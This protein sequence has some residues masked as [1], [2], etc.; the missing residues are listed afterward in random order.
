MIRILVAD[1]HPLFRAGVAAVI[2]CQADMVVVGEATT[3]T[4]AVAMARSE[5][6]D[7]VL[8]DLQMPDMD[9]LTALDAIRREFPAIRI[10]VVTTYGGDVQKARALRLGACGYLLKETLHADLVD[11]IRAVML[12]ATADAGN[13][14][15]GI[16][17]A[18][19]PLLPREMAVLEHL[20]RGLSN[21][22]I[23]RAL[24]LSSGTVKARVGDILSKL[25]ARD[26]THAA[27][28][29]IKRGIIAL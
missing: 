7:V 6:P 22:D 3:G 27:V 10:L 29:A 16:P 2:G 26:R 13:E 8:L 23:A 21:D 12:P 5:M 24:R 25:D 28:I 17:F 18:A 9:G 20:V 4:E 19:E 15:G 11:N 14:H 1:D